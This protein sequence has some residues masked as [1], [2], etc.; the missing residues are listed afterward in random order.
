MRNWLASPVGKGWCWRG[1]ALRDGRARAVRSRGSK[2]ENSLCDRATQG[3]KEN[4]RKEVQGEK[5]AGPA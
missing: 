3:D 2:A 1:A 5:V 4:G